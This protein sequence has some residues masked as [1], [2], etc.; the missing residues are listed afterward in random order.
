M[1][2][3]VGRSRLVAENLHSSVV[4]K[5]GCRRSRRHQPRDGRCPPSGPL[6]REHDRPVLVCGESGT[7]TTVV[8]RAIHVLASALAVRSSSCAAACWLRTFSSTT[9]RRRTPPVA[10]LVARAAQCSSKISKPSRF[11]CRNSCSRAVFRNLPPQQQPRR[12]LGRVRIVVSSH[13][14]LNQLVNEG[15]FKSRTA[16]AVQAAQHRSGSAAR[17]SEDIAP[18]AEQFLLECSVPRRPVAEAAHS[19]ALQR[20]RNHAW[21][22]TSVSCRT[23]QPLLLDRFLRRDLGL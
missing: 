22:A 9:V 8:A 21:P 4:W 11:L 17:S 12:A 7:G 18:L 14:D 1:F 3:A 13:A 19:E 5:A 2:S 16:A 10:S 15:K 6:G 20:L 23:D